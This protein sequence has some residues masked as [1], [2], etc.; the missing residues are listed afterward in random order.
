[1]KTM[2]TNKVNENADDYSEYVERIID[3]RIWNIIL[4]K[5]KE[6]DKMDILDRSKTKKARN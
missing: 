1:M 4:L 2:L 5:R 3:L 6:D